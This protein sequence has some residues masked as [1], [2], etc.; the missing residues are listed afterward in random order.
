MIG[1]FMKNEAIITYGT[2]FLRGFCLGMPFMCMDFLGVNVFQSLGKGK[3]AFV[4]AILR[5]IVLEIPLLFVLN[6]LFPLYGLAYAQ[7][8]AEMVLAIAAVVMLRRMFLKTGNG[9]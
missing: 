2:W 1:A 3:V 8:T 9:I 7:A 6:V 4:F 5:K